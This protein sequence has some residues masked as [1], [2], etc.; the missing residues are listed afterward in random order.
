MANTYT[1]RQRVGLVILF[2]VLEVSDLVFDWEFFAELSNSDRYKEAPLRW[3][4]LAF[5]LWGTVNFVLALCAL[6]YSVRRRERHKFEDLIDISATLLE[7]V[8]QMIMAAI[9]AV[10]EGEPITNWVQYTKAILA[11]VE[12]LLRCIIILVTCCPRLRKK[13]H[14]DDG[15]DTEGFY[16]DDCTL[17]CVS[18]WMNFI[19]YLAI[20][21][22][23]SV[24]LI[25]F[26][27]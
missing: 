27:R 4:V 24:V 21:I 16:N 25:V 22:C 17:P 11:I 1:A 13:C 7:D 10:E 5:A 20:L 14:G 2:V 12:A 8:P 23:A 26:A 19:G 15:Y 6:V 9:V 3:A 18:N